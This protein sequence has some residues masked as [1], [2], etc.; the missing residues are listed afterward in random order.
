MGY[1]KQT[2][3]PGSISHNCHQLYT[4]NESY[5]IKN[6]PCSFFSKKDTASSKNEI[7][8]KDDSNNLNE[9]NI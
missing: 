1:Y 5:T 2:C 3:I 7:K 6:I 8:Q 9:E 4:I